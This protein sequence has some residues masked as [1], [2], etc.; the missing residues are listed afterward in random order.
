MP[1]ARE[2]R[3]TTVTKG[4][5]NSVRNASFRFRI[6][7]LRVTGDRRTSR[8]RHPLGANGWAGKRTRSSS[9]HASPSSWGGT[10]P[11]PSRQRNRRRCSGLVRLSDTFALS[12]NARSNTRGR[13]ALGRSLRRELGGHFLQTRVRHPVHSHRAL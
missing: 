10:P 3:A 2:S 7:G 4:V 5:L 6:Y 8:V 1:S 9:P 11:S 13:L 12:R